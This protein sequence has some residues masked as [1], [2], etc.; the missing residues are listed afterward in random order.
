[1]K[2]FLFLGLSFFAISAC[3]NT[4]NAESTKPS[5]AS[6]TEAPVADTGLA[7]VIIKQPEIKNSNFPLFVFLHGFGANEDDFTDLAQFFP[8]D[9]M[10]ISLRAPKTLQEGSYSWYDNHQTMSGAVPD[11]LDVEHSK[12]AIIATIKRLGKTVAYDPKKVFVGG[13]SQGANLS[14]LLGLTNPNM[15]K[16]IA[17]FSG[18]ILPTTYSESK[19]RKVS[20]FAIFAGHGTVD[21]RISYTD[22]KAAIKYVESK[23]LHP[24]F[25]SYNMRHQMIEPEILDFQ[26]W[27]EKEDK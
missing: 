27:L 20:S 8:K 4:S 10:V 2:S 19:N 22:A 21:D 17:V 15:F 26:K 13:F 3:H 6:T 25:H 9:F 5:N 16:G 12:D 23:G 11:S 7:Y 1:M 24:E 18:K 14:Y